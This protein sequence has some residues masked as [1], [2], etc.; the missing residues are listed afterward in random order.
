MVKGFGHSIFERMKLM[1]FNSTLTTERI[2][3]ESVTERE[4]Y[5]ENNWVNHL[6]KNQLNDELLLRAQ[7]GNKEFKTLNNLNSQVCIIE[8]ESFNKENSY[9]GNNYPDAVH[10]SKIVRSVFE[11]HSFR[12]FMTMQNQRLVI[13][14][15]D[16][17]P[18]K[19]RKEQ[20]AKKEKL[21]LISNQI[22]TI[23]NR[24]E[25]EKIRVFMGVS[26]S[27][28]G[29]ES[30]YYSYDEASKAIF[31]KFFFK[32]SIIFYD[33]LGAFQIL[34]NL[35]EKEMLQSYV[36]RHLGPLIEE[37]QKKNSD[38][39]K[40]LKIY[41]ER[42]GSKQSAADELHIVRQ[43]LYYRLEKIKELLGEDFMGIQNRLA[44][45]LAFQAYELLKFEAN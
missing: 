33:D 5:K 38:L 25:C 42:N 6:I 2:V 32:S 28:K 24:D 35:Y 1:G 40:T 21:Q 45:Q 8:M 37:D 11:Q 27:Y 16:L 29:F 4:L 34:L 39:L 7:L 10:Y 26:S 14:A 17:F 18:T 44:L 30:S 19:T 15:F 43:S 22:D 9:V 36:L 41:L 20:L 12:P 3:K 13:L 31:L 23:L